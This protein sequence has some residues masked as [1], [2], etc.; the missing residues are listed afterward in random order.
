MTKRGV[1][2]WGGNGADGPVVA[3]LFRLYQD[4]EEREN[5]ENGTAWRGIVQGMENWLHGLIKHGCGKMDEDTLREAREKLHRLV[6]DA[7]LEIF[8]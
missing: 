6:A 4:R 2:I 3:L 8:G 1:A 5:A 7:N